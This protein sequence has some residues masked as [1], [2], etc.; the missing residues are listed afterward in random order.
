MLSIQKKGASCSTSTLA[1]HRATLLAVDVGTGASNIIIT[2]FSCQQ[3]INNDNV[4]FLFFIFR[5]LEMLFLIESYFFSFNCKT[6]TRL[7][8]FWKEREP[9]YSVFLLQRNLGIT[10]HKESAATSNVRC[11]MVGSFTFSYL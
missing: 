6:G 7:D 3:K 5:S 2:Y 10:N 9:S 11:Q 8:I 4:S 1:C